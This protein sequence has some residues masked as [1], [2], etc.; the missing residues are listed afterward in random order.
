[1]E[2]RLTSTEAGTFLSIETRVLATDPNTRRAFAAYWFFI[3]PSSAAIR[4]EVLRIVA[5]RAESI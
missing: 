2:Y 5:S 3:Q 1:M 4:R